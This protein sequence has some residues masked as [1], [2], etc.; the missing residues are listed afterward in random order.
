VRNAA[1]VCEAFDAVLALADG[2]EVVQRAH[3]GPLEAVPGRALSAPGDRHWSGP[4]GGASRRR[5]PHRV[6]RSGPLQD[7]EP[8]RGC[9]LGAAWAAALSHAGPS[10][11]ALSVASVS[12][13]RRAGGHRRPCLG[14]GRPRPDLSPTER[15]PGRR[16]PA[17]PGVRGRPRRPLR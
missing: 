2:D 14:P 9:V 4:P 7:P 10:D 12:N 1:R 8:G 11:Q 6:A 17:T 15:G 13:T 16:G 3:H 5:D